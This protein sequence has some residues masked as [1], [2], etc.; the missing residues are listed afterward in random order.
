MHGLRAQIGIGDDLAMRDVAG[1]QR[2]CTA[3]SAKVNCAVA[4]HAFNYGGAAL[5]L[6]HHAQQPGIQQGGG[7]GVHTVAG[8][9]ARC[10]H[11]MAG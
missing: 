1:D 7:I 9:G 2:R 8:G 4:Y 5:A 3:D 6:T 10:A 11:G